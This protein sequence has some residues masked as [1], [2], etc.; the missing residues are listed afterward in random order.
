M[1]HK[2]IT[3]NTP[4]NSPRDIVGLTGHAPKTF[5]EGTL[6]EIFNVLYVD[7]GAFPFEYQDQLA[8][9]VQLIYDHFK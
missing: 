6:L 5:S 7:C 8:K 4:T 3:F 2:I 9:G 1:G